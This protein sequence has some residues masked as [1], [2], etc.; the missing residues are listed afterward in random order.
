V[1]QL[2]YASAATRPFSPDD[3]E[4]LLEKSRARNRFYDVTGIL[5]YHNG[6]FLQVLEGPEL[7]V[8]TIFAS[9]ERDPRHRHSKVLVRQS[10]ERPEFGD[11]AMSFTNTS[12]VLQRPSGLVD[13]HRTLPAMVSGATEAKRYLRFFQQ[14]LCRQGNTI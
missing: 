7:G 14:G 3:L 11:W 2:V 10:L 5:L 12:L 4:V 6:S 1:I 13:Y 9:I 8:G